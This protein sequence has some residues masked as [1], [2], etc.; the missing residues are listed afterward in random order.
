[1]YKI[2]NKSMRYSMKKIFYKEVWDY[3]PTTKAEAYYRLKALGYENP[4]EKQIIALWLLG[5]IV[6]D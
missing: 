2:K 6:E 4:T 5:I 1:M 3:R